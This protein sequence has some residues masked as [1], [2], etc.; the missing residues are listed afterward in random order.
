MWRWSLRSSQPCQINTFMPPLQF[1]RQTV[2]TQYIRT[3]FKNLFSI[4]CVSISSPED[5]L[6]R[7]TALET[8]EII[9]RHPEILGEGGK[10]HC[11]ELNESCF[12]VKMQSGRQFS[13]PNGSRVQGD[14]TAEGRT[15]PA[16]W[17]TKLHWAIEI[18]HSSKIKC[19][20]YIHLTQLTCQLPADCIF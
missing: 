11:C 12:A 9:S 17:T 5:V 16:V 18:S 15:E 2:Q 6:T 20:S 8:G 7:N 4:N 1:A 3:C 19:S 10:Q 13:E 14:I